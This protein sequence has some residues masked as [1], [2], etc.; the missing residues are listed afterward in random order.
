[1][2]KSR[3]KYFQFLLE[4]KLSELKSLSIGTN[5]K[6]L[7]LGIMKGIKLITPSIS[8]QNQFTSIVE[9]IDSIKE[10]QSQSTQDINNL[11]NAL[12][13]KAFKGEIY[14]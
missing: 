12:M 13:Q 6:Y 1:M 3:Y 9:K 7:T 5:T 4:K 14:A 10:Q 11:F 2:A 8:L